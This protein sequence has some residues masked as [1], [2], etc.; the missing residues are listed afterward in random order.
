MLSIVIPAYNEAD[1]IGA[2]VA[3][4]A[5]QFERAGREYEILV[6]DDASSD[7]TEA[8]LDELEKR[9]P[10]L[11]HVSNPGPNGYGYAVRT[12]LRH[13]RGDAVVIAMADASDSP[14]DMLAYGERIGQGFDCAF[15]SRFVPGAHVEDYPPVKRV[16]N[17]LGNRLIALLLRQR[18]YDFSNGFK[19]YRREVIEG[20][21]P[22][23]SGEF[24]LTVEM[25][26]KALL[27]G[28][29][30][31]VVPNDW[32][33]RSAGGSKFHITAQGIPYLLSIL[34]CLIEQRL[35]R[36]RRRA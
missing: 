33:N 28:A 1:T 30:F 15:G 23:V 14:A 12:G 22:L 13:F 2:T 4:I 16:L 17:R 6:V 10:R 25:S 36:P 34:Y 8:T 3:E 32:R 21:E 27:N 24:N 9:F 5:A 20:M 26:M 18:Y 7:A 19:C 35:K 29:S 11:R 31:A